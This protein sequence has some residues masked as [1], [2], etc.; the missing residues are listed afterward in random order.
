[1]IFDPD[2]R[3]AY[4]RAEYSEL[5]Y[6]SVFCFRTVKSAAMKLCI[7]FTICLLAFVRCED[8][9]DFAGPD[10]SDEPT[11]PVPDFVAT[12]IGDADDVVVGP[13]HS[14]EIFN[15]RLDEIIKNKIA[16][17]H[18]EI[19]PYNLSDQRTG[20][21]RKIGPLNM[22]GEAGFVD[23]KL[24]GL[25]NVMRLEDAYL[26]RTKWGN[27]EMS[28]GLRVGPLELTT[29]GFAR[30]LGIGP[31]V[32]YKIN[33]V[34]VDTTAVLHFNNRTDKVAVKS[35]KVSEIL[36]LSFKITKAPGFVTPFVAN[37]IING[38]ISVFKPLIKTAVTKTG[39]V[40]LERLIE[41]SDF[42]KDVMLEADMIRA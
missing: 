42:V 39:G 41:D 26:G 2:N 29:R 20:F 36:G 8:D 22:T 35:F 14:S 34:Q 19:V 30:F 21:W 10:G 15:K 27:V 13:T 12:E 1:M 7:L 28:F 40:L 31:R 33:V 32:A 37:Q 18:D 11:A 38:G 4:L 16:E 9:E 6:A 24:Y 5:K 3:Y 17:H 25:V 23:N